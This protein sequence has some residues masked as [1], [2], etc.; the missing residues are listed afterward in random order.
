VKDTKKRWLT[1]IPFFF[2]S[3]ISPVYAETDVNLLTLHEALG[4]RLGVGTF[5]GGLIA[6]AILLMMTIL[7]VALI[8]RS[9]K[10][11]GG[12]IAEI[13]VGLTVL[14]VCI[15]ITWLPVW[16]LLVVTLIL[17]LAYMDKIKGVV[18]SA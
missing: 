17:A 10:G 4:E 2:L 6:S 9:R 13:V 1:L 8:N 18:G 16:L 7:P 11:G 12:P 5:A 15:A 14:S 3:L